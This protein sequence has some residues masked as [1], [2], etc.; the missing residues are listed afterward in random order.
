MSEGIDIRERVAAKD[1]ELLDWAETEVIGLTA[2]PFGWEIWYAGEDN[3]PA[4]PDPV[5]YQ[6]ESMREAL[7]MA[8]ARQEAEIELSGNSGELAAIEDGSPPT[9]DI[10][11]LFNA[12]SFPVFPVFPTPV[13][14]APRIGDWIQTYSGIAFYPCDPIPE[15]VCIA[16]IA[17]ALSNLC[18]FTGHTKYFYSVAE[19]CVHV[20][21]LCPP[22]HA[23][24]G[25]LHDA[26]E[27]YVSDLSRPVKL[28]T[29][30]GEE[31]RRVEA[32][33]QA[34]II[35]AFGLPEKEPAEVKSADNRMLYVEAEHLMSPLRPGWAKWASLLHGDEPS[36]DTPCWTP[37][38]AKANFMER[39]AFVSDSRK[40]RGQVRN[41]G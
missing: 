31:Y 32:V 20:S 25:L 41:G 21:R 14:K 6:T 22:E 19:H 8:K 1:T 17:H 18:R 40:F 10:K 29:A 24:W 37:E 9:L 38:T 30:L 33:L 5:L 12:G 36:L 34:S 16:D 35:A 11:Q 26:S 27:A 23:L 7:A 15:E 39:F 13:I 4:T 2:H 3:E 28:H